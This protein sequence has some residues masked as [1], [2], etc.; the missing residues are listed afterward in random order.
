METAISEIYK[1]ILTKIG[2][3]EANGQRPKKAPIQ[4]RA[5]E[6]RNPDDL[7]RLIYLLAEHHI[8]LPNT[9]ANLLPFGMDLAKLHRGLG[10]AAPVEEISAY[11]SLGSQLGQGTRSEVSDIIAR[12]IEPRVVE[13]PPKDR[14]KIYETL[15]A[16]ERGGGQGLM[17]YQEIN[18]RE[19]KDVPIPKFNSGF[20]PLDEVTGGLYQGIFTFMAPPGTG[21]TSMF[22]TIMEM[23]ALNSIPVWKFQN[24]IP[25]QMIEGR[26]SPIARRTRLADNCRLFCGPYTSKEVCEAVKADPDPNRVVIFDSPDV[27]TSGGGD[28]RIELESS[29]QDLVRLKAFCRAIIIPSQPKA[30]DV[31]SPG[32]TSPAES[33]AKVWYTDALVSVV[34][35]AGSQCIMKAHKNRF[36]PMGRQCVFR[37]DYVDLTFHVEDLWQDLQMPGSDDQEADW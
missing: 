35:A 19:V 16:L 17:E 34:R 7:S 10:A 8:Q 23:L 4:R 6:R 26:L 13:T 11:Y 28:R 33:W 15:G 21:K 32:L 37:Y 31:D 25:P 20:T 9:L 12:L 24:E 2:Q 22:L 5:L 36:G 3:E 14:I 29:Y 30:K 27:M 1:G 18:L